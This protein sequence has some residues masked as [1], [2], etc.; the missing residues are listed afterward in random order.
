M[1]PEDLRRLLDRDAPRV[2]SVLMR[3]RT[4]GERDRGGLGRL[5]ADARLLFL[6][7]SEKL[8]PRRRLLFALAVVAAIVGAFGFEIT[9]D[10]SGTDFRLDASPL[11]LLISV[12]ALL[13]LLAA[14]LVDRILVRDEL[15]VA[16]QLQSELLPKSPPV[17]EG[18]A[19]AASW[20]TANDIGGD[21]HRFERLADGRTAIVV[22]DASGHGMAAG[23]LMAVTDT[24]LRI[25]LEL[26]PE[27][28]AV[29][30]LLHRA[31]RRL[32][33]RRSFVTLF[34]GRLDPAT[35]RLEYASA[36]HPSPLL[37]RAGGEVEEPAR[38]SRPLGLGER[39]EP[40]RGELVLAPGDLVVLSTDGLFEAIGAGKETFGWDRL[41]QTVAR[42]DGGAIAV[43]DRLRDEIVRHVGDEPVSDDRTIVVVER[44]P[45]APP[46]T[47]A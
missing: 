26:D 31:L 41:R 27:P 14:E 30:A 28:G 2:Y 44:L 4:R 46:A 3:D 39:C 37:R 43:H 9:Y 34:Y 5:F 38:G 11:L 33:D 20:Q 8:T 10:D 36:G 47:L 25:A 12:A 6:S 35:G 32:G 22:A 29:A 17:V 15:E 13:F 23:L 16:R 19:F 21:Y 18:W 1:A 40:D 24:A 42:A 7:I 45:T